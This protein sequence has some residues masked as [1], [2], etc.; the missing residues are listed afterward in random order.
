MLRKLSVTTL[1]SFSMTNAMAVEWTSIIH[2]ANHEVLVDIDSYNV[3]EG[4]PFLIAKT[5]HQKPQTFVLPSEKTQYLVS[6][7]KL[8]FNCKKPMYRTRSIQLLD[9]NKKL[10]DTI[11]INSQFKKIEANTDAFSI[12]QLTCQ[13]HQMVGG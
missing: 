13:V 1:L 9:N 3:S 7:A 8:Q 5:I 2:D 6:I 11:K 10:I 12:G 4:F